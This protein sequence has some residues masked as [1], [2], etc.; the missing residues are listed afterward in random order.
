MGSQ[1]CCSPL[2]LFAICVAGPLKELCDSCLAVCGSSRAA[3]ESA[4]IPQIIS[5]G[6]MKRERN[7]KLNEIKSA[8]EDS[9]Q[10]SLVGLEILSL[11]R[12]VSFS[13]SLFTG[14]LTLRCLDYGRAWEAL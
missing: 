14:N 4:A 5:P 7:K 11:K 2:G 6:G 8:A 10:T 1:H 12:S 9:E 3:G 13:S